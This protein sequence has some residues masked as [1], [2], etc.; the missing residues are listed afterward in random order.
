[1]W[2]ETS[3]LCQGSQFSHI[4]AHVK[5]TGNPDAHNRWCIQCEAFVAS[6]QHLWWEHIKLKQTNATDA[7]RLQI[8]IPGSGQLASRTKVSKLVLLT[9]ILVIKQSYDRCLK[10]SL[11][12][13]GEFFFIYLFFYC[14]FNI[15]YSCLCQDNTDTSELWSENILNSFIILI[16]HLI[17]PLVQL[18]ITINLPCLCTS[19][20]PTLNYMLM[21]VIKTLLR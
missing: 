12:S 19:L 6:W 1:M 8:Q 2:F 17:E 20:T 14:K 4:K 18:S 15:L 7:V 21:R 13:F 3:P 10:S 16:K 9:N 11:L 5:S